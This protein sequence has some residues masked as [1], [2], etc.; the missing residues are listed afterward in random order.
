MEI[1]VG[2]ADNVQPRS[3]KTTAGAR[4]VDIGL[5]PQGR[6]MSLDFFRGFT[7]FLLIGEGTRIYELL[8]APELSGTFVSAIGTQFHHHPWN[9][10]RFWDLIQPFFMFIVGVA[11][12]FSI[13]KR[14]DQGDTWG[15]TFR[16]ALQRSFWLLFFG[17]A[18]YCIGPGRITFELW[19]VL[20]QLSF[21]Y[22][23][24]F[25]M[26][27]KSTPIQIAFTFGLLL[28]TELV[29]RLWPVAGFN[30]PFVPDHNFGS[31]VD[32]L[33]MGKLSGGHW[34]AFNAVPTTAHTMW[35]VLAGQL[36]KSERTAWQKIKILI[37]AG[38]IGVG[39]GYALDPVTPI[40][41]R[42]C[43]SSFVIV[44]G[45]WCLLALALSYWLVDVKKFQ[46]WPRFFVYVGMN[47]L[48]IYLF[49]ETGG[50][51][52]VD[53]IVRPF[54]MG[55]FGWT[56]ALPASIVTSFVVWGALW[57]ICYWLYQKRI[58]VKI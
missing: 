23:V 56:G 16:H 20:A 55:I 46:K 45:G 27:R 25:L 5:A 35:G 28:V 40:I 3:E 11:M 22:L 26:M 8:I 47:S 7:M 18:L 48:L 1:K 21:T 14:W 54:T 39:V 13:G 10:L 29:Y 44:S 36:L 12:P 2:T 42:I 50:A 34:V 43:T 41:K 32:L 19:N 57:T 37:I 51:E 38:L 6:L 17:W 4:S 58:F 30:Q 9:G 31:Y 52:W 15:A 49:T 53:K 24:A 33:L